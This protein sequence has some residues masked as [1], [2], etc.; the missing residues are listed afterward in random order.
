MFNHLCNQMKQHWRSWTCLLVV[1]IVQQRIT[2]WPSPVEPLMAWSGNFTLKPTS[3]TLQGAQ[4]TQ[5]KNQNE[6]EVKF[7]YVF[8]LKWHIRT[9][10][11]HI[12]L[13]SQVLLLLPEE[14]KLRY[15]KLYLN[16]HWIFQ[17]LLISFSWY[18]VNCSSLEPSPP[19][20]FCISQNLLW[21][22]FF[23]R[24]FHFKYCETFVKQK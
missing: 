9:D 3:L 1:Q 16:A 24:V 19:N 6:N 20:T 7:L 11:M 18:V 10:M 13:H 8:T 12:W 14:K 21:K 23:V 17:T 5:K 4:T 15:L 22:V 2:L